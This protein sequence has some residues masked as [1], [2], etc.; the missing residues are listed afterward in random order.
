MAQDVDM[1][2]RNGRVVDGTGAEPF[3]A[4]ISKKLAALKL[5]LEDKM[6]GQSKFDDSIKRGAPPPMKKRRVVTTEQNT[7]N[8]VGSSSKV[9]TQK[10]A[11]PPKSKSTGKRNSKQITQQFFK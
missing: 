11:P 8:F 10:T 7:A 4:D 5:K 6:C 9:S 2:V 1:V 3:D